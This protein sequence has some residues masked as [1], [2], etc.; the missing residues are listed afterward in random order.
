MNLLE[1]IKS[2]TGI[3]IHYPWC[4]QKCSYCDFYSVPAG[5]PDSTEF[6][7]K[8]SKYLQTLLSELH[9]R[10]ETFHKNEVSSVYFGGGTSSLMQPEW[11]EKILSEIRKYFQLS[12]CEV[13]LEGN[14]ENFSDDYLKSLSEAGISR[15]NAGFQSF[16][17]KNLLK[18]QRFYKMESYLEAI[19]AL[20]R[21]PVKNW[22]GDL[23]YGLPDQTEE[24]FYSDL[25]M[26]LSY[27]P[28]HLSLYSLTVEE[29]TALASQILKKKIS[30]PDELLQQKILLE[31]RNFTKAYGFHQYEVSNFSLKSYE[32]FHN[33]RYWLYLPYLGIGP[34]AHGF[35]GRSRYGNPRNI[36]TWLKHPHDSELISQDPINEIPLMILRLTGAI[37]INYIISLLENHI[38]QFNRSSHRD[39]IESLIKQWTD[40]GY[41]E[42]TNQTESE[43]FPQDENSRFFS[44]TN[45][46]LQFLD[47]RVLEFSRLSEKL[48]EL[49]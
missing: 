48:L 46:G 26:L 29:N 3:Y 36:E 27:N 35:N 42:Y 38:P 2:K 41:A 18:L 31:L 37:S 15:V 10:A 4:M 25:K 39:G 40:Q 12:D 34:G 33:L 14:P 49:P 24:E 30:G 28:V 45:L 1:K 16:S 9:I 47:E 8:N 22:G 23:M 5:S 7:Q 32:C 20:S 17:E 19:D 11:I 6:H 21:S 43:I 44:W 13:T